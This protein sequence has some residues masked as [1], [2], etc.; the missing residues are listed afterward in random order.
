[1]SQISGLLSNQPQGSLPSNTEVNPKEH[2]KA[3]MLRSG[4]VLAQDQV[5]RE[6]NPA[7]TDIRDENSE[8]E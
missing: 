6:K 3:I 1:M 5:S 8:Q 4:K 7:S 2:V